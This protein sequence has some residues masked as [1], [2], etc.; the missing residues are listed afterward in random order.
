[1]DEKASKLFDNLKDVGF[2]N[3]KV[4]ELQ[5]LREGSLDIENDFVRF[6]LRDF[7]TKASDY[8]PDLVREL[9]ANAKHWVNDDED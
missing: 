2:S 1:M 4:F 7:C 9:Y 3:H 6:G 8:Y 5:S